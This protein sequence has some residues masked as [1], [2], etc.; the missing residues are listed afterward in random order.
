MRPMNGERERDREKERARETVASK[1][2]AGE[3]RVREQESH[4][5][6]RES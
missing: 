1:T 4:P 6:P 3:I 2:R 5:C